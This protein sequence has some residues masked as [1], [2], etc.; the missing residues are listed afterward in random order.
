MHL[1]VVHADAA[2]LSIDFFVDSLVDTYKYPVSKSFF[3]FSSPSY[4]LCLFSLTETG[5]DP[6]IQLPSVMRQNHA[7]TFCY[8]LYSKKTQQLS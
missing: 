8:M 7:A 2:G 3:S 6:V 4:K 1:F 5:N